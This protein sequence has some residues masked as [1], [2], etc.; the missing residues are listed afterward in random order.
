M[1]LPQ[2]NPRVKIGLVVVSASCISELRYP[3]AAPAGVGFLTSR[4]L[5]GADQG[6]DG[7][8]AMEANSARA[9]EE[10]ASAGVDAIAYCCTVSGA[11]RGP[12]PDRQFCADMERQWRTPT[13]STML[14]AVEALQHLQA[15]RI[16]VATP[17]PDSH[18]SA[19]QAYLE[20]SG[21][22][23]LAMRGM[24]LHTAAEFAA[25]PPA[26]IRRFCL[27]AWE[28]WAGQADALFISCMNLDGMAAAQSLEDAIGK[29]VV[30]SHSAT[31]WRALSLAGVADPVPGY[32]RLLAQP[33]AIRPQPPRPT[34][35]E[36]TAV[37]TMALA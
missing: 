5:L 22:Q 31:L 11:L 1:V 7:L 25:V 34:P 3:Q 23:P 33:R 10:L 30:T 29:P 15:Q 18:H 4:M 21:I 6:L 37:E 32:G 12:E 35:S 20:A 13:T 27:E 9:V 24:G 36:T 28:P 14:A 2:L 26:E 16:V 8:R 19:E 17:Y